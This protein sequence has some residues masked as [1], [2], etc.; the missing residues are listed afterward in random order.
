MKIASAILVLPTDPDLGPVSGRRI[1]LTFKPPHPRSS[2]KLPLLVDGDGEVLGLEAFRG[3]RVKV[4]AFIETD[5]PAYVREVLGVAPEEP[6]I[7]SPPPPGPARYAL[8]PL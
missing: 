8:P 5:D 6:G 4:G 7:K 1:P 3:L 2:R